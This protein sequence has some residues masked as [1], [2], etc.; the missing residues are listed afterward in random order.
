MTYNVF[1]GMLNPTQSIISV[2]H[3]GIPTCALE[4]ST[5][6]RIRTQLVGHVLLLN[7]AHKKLNSNAFHHSTLTHQASYS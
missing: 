1:S 3:I 4:I 7:R 6:G 5:K 2:T